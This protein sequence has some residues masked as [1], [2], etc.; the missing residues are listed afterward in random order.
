VGGPYTNLDIANLLQISGGIS[1]RV[2][3]T[4]GDTLIG[5]CKRTSVAEAIVRCLELRDDCANIDFSIIDNDDDIVPLTDDELRESLAS[6][7][8]GEK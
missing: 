7:K 6:M 5:D 1:N 2:T 4:R 8:G 3:M